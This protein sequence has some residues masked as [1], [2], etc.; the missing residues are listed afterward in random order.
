LNWAFYSVTLSRL[1]NRYEASGNS[2]A[3]KLI[4][5]MSSVAW[6]RI[7]I[8][9]HYTFLGNGQVIVLDSIVAGLEWG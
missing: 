6:R 8:N 3:L 9:G 4:T 1:L 5:Q 2:K 7:L